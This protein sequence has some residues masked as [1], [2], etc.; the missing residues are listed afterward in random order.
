MRISVLQENLNKAL[1]SV[2]RV[3]A[4]KAQLPVLNNVLLTVEKGTLRLT[5]TN[6]ELGMVVPIGAKVQA[7]GAICVPAKVFSELVGELP[8]GEV[9]L[10][11]E[12]QKLLIRQG[13]FTADLAGM[14]AGEF[15]ALPPFDKKRLM[16]FQADA[17]LR[18]LKRVIFSAAT[19]DGRPV[20]TGVCF[21]LAGDMPRMAATD[22]FRLSVVSLSSEGKAKEKGAEETGGIETA[23]IP[24]RALAEVVRLASEEEIGETITVS[25]GKERQVK[26]TVGKAELL[27]RLIDGEYPDYG[28]ILPKDKVASFEGDKETFVRVVRMAAIFAR[29]SANVVKFTI[30]KGVMKVSATSQNLGTNESVLEGKAEGEDGFC[31]AFN[32]RYLLDFLTNTDGEEIKIDFSGSL[33]PGMFMDPKEKDFTHVIMPVRLQS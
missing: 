30:G 19:D 5:T 8:A 22:G 25:G 12:D 24:A 28:K 9:D 7:E 29:E 18:S 4:S 1:T 20:L 33:S 17:F 26:F 23:I 11:V 14:G 27:T 6:L 32:Y 2:S 13:D 3:V 10:E 31:V 15:P 21:N 16:E